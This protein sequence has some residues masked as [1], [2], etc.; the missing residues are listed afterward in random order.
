MEERDSLL[1]QAHEA[2]WQ[3]QFAQAYDIYEALLQANPDDPQV[4]LDYGRAVFG[5][6]NDFE[7]ATRLFEQAVQSD[8]TSV[9]AVLWLADMAALGYGPEQAGAV[10]LYRRALELDPACVDA[11]IGLGLQYRAP[12][13]TLTLEE[14][15]QAF[16]QAATLDPRRSDAS[17]NLG[18][19]LLE[20][21]KRPEA[22]AALRDAIVRMQGTDRAR[23]IPAIQK[24]IERIERGEPIKKKAMFN[25]SPRYRWLFSS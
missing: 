25:D 15:L 16:R 10:T 21:G 2:C 22:L 13:V 9:E 5:E 8:P 23:Q 3:F 24:Y 6:G 11:Y 12:S 19:L 7:K 20:E 17:A 4:L 1:Q 14:S 18:M